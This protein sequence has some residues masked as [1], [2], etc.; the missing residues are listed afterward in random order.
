MI[1]E[2]FKIKTLDC[3][4]VSKSYNCYINLLLDYVA[5]GTKI[6]VFKARDVNAFIILK[7]SAI[8]L[9]GNS[10]GIAQSPP[11]TLS[12]VEIVSALETCETN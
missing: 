6:L 10:A 7:C 5:I 9:P 2:T 1:E 4:I 8:P 12:F 3:L 11:F